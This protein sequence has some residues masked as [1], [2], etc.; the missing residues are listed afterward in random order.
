M[1]EDSL[2]MNQSAVDRGFMRS[3]HYRLY[4][5]EEAKLGNHLC[6]QFERPTRETCANI[7]Q[8]STTT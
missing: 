2:I 1:Q 5:E 3:T 7:R 6:E 4:K 8:V